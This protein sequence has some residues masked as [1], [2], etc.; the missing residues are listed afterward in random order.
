MP[1]D[2]IADTSKI[3]HYRMDGVSISLR[4]EEV[5]SR[6]KNLLTLVAMVLMSSMHNG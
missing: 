2:R 5:S 3:K 4:L 1:M 6:V